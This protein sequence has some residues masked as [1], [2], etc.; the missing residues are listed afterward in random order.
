LTNRLPGQMFGWET[1]TLSVN[2]MPLHTH[3]CSGASAEGTAVTPV[4]NVPAVNSDGVQHYTS[5]PSG[6]VMHSSMIGSTGDSQPHNNM[7]PSLVMNY[8]IC[9][10]GTFPSRS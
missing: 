1:H 5:P 8:I 9:C 4:N 3:Q 10:E 7:Q 2:E 6:P